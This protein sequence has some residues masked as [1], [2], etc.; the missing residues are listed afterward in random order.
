MTRKANEIWS[1]SSI[2]NS[3]IRLKPVN[4]IKYS[5]FSI[6][7]RNKTSGYSLV[8]RQ[9]SNN[10]SAM[11]PCS[12]RQ[13][14]N[15]EIFDS[16]LSWWLTDEL[17]ICDITWHVYID[18]GDLESRSSSPCFILSTRRQ[19]S[20]L[21]TSVEHDPLSRLVEDLSLTKTEIITNACPI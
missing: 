9:T 5:V 17:V 15:E 4:Y 21:Y 12:I 11:L 20:F 10:A 1:N 19:W 18:S 6:K 2:Q 7:N 8:R 16:P 3:A 13:C 14:Y